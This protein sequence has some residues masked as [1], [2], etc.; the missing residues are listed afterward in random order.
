M[1]TRYQ[2][3]S[4][5]RLPREIGVA[6]RFAGW[7]RVEVLDGPVLQYFKLYHAPRSPIVAGALE[8]EVLPET[9]VE[10][11]LLHTQRIVVP[12]VE[13]Y[14]SYSSLVEKV[15]RFSQRTFVPEVPLIV[16]EHWEERRHQR[17]TVKIQ[18]P[19][20]PHE[21]QVVEGPGRTFHFAISGQL[22]DKS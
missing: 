6:L 15:V 4:S 21:S 8:N 13:G 18:H 16:W 10:L 20:P 3:S 12:V 1:T 22:K 19:S 2:S 9:P 17:L 5:T 11:L 7:S 14:W